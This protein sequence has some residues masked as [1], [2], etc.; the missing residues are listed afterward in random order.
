MLSI[1]LVVL[2]C[3]KKQV[4]PQLDEQPV[5]EFPSEPPPSESSQKEYVPESSELPQIEEKDR[6]LS[7]VF[8]VYFC[9]DCDFV[10]NSY[11]DELEELAWHLIQEPDVYV[12]ITGFTCSMGDENYN[13]EL[14]LRRSRT[15]ESMLNA[16]GVPCEIECRSLGENPNYFLAN[17]P[18]N[19]WKNRRVEI[20]VR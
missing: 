16:F 3:S 8:P 13:F 1:L 9:F 11:V 12:L 19:F 15:I 18:V 5:L 14:G 6:I 2:G 7:T 4:V 20:E 10:D 17:D